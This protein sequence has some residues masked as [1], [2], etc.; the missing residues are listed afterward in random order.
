VG[1]RGEIAPDGPPCATRARADRQTAAVTSRSRVAAVLSTGLLV[2]ALAGCAV[3]GDSTGPGARPS[4]P[5]ENQNAESSSSPSPSASVT[6]TAPPS[7]IAELGSLSG[8]RTQV[9][10][11]PAFLQTLTKAALKPVAGG[12]AT[13][14]ASGLLTLP[15]TGGSL[16]V[17]AASGA[18]AAPTA[19]G[20]IAHRGSGLQLTGGNKRVTLRDLVID[21]GSGRVT[22]TES[23]NGT[24]SGTNAPIFT[25]GE[26]GLQPPTKTATG[27]V[28]L[29]GATL[30]LTTE[31]AHLLN[32]TFGA[33]EVTVD[34]QVGTVVI[35]AK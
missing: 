32:T 3:P 30:S 27:E 12:T 13:L 2:A 10:F 18:S 11:D 15:I 28:V 19:Q 9:T 34:Q 35:T 21:P 22:G 33:P 8:V 14:S 24:V 31:A 16:R 23:V 26:T 7:P 6:P 17:F 20:S 4:Q 29:R 1:T 5:I 25:L